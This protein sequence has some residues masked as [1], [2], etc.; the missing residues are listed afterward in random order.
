MPRAFNNPSRYTESL[1]RFFLSLVFNVNI[2]SYNPNPF[3]KMYIFAHWGIY[4]MLFAR[5]HW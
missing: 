2:N 4:A 1:A 5:G 3:P